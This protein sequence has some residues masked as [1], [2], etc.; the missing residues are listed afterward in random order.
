MIYLFAIRFV[1][2]MSSLPIT[3]ISGCMKCCTPDTCKSHTFRRAENC[4]SQFTGI[5]QKSY[6]FGIQ[7]INCRSAS[8]D[9]RKIVPCENC[10][11]HLPENRKCKEEFD[12]YVNEAR[13]A[14]KDMEKG[15]KNE[16][17]A[18][19]V[20]QQ[21]WFQEL[22][23]T[24]QTVVENQ[25]K[26]FDEIKKMLTNLTDGQKDMIHNQKKMS[27][28]INDLGGT[29]ID[30]MAK[31]KEWYTTLN[32]NDI[33]ILNGQKDI[34]A[35]SVRTNEEIQKVANEVNSLA[36]QIE[37]LEIQEWYKDNI[38]AIR[39]YVQ[40]PNLA[41]KDEYGN[42]DLNDPAVDGWL[43][44]SFPVDASIHMNN[45]LDM[46]IGQDEFP[47][48]R[49]SIYAVAGGSFCHAKNHEQFKYQLQ[50][51]YNLLITATSLNPSDISNF[52]DVFA[53]K[54]VK[55][56]EAY[57][58]NC[59]CDD[60][61]RILMSKTISELIPSLE[62]TSLSYEENLLLIAKSSFSE[63]V[64]EKVLTLLNYKNFYLY[65]RDNS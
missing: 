9:I 27:D 18:N 41:A 63:L 32:H 48:P 43:K 59:G 22:N 24:L 7:N 19:W 54:L 4:L 46:L 10:E 23:S 51:V 61:Q 21:K 2:M 60:G 5:F 33:Q 34:L 49:P 65:P 52:K 25:A 50:F 12:N 40:Y 1:I 57:A 64:R 39:N 47:I 16:I 11:G 37:E 45:I 58:I 35:A 15:I 17:A 36:I 14:L 56:D 44:D 6:K 3:F 53:K 29:I 62:P 20:K 13:Q 26:E 8:I 30:N 42:L 38:K 28:A 31:Q 55:S